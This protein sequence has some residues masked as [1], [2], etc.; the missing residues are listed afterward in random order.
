MIFLFPSDFALVSAFF[1]S[2]VSSI[3]SESIESSDFDFPRGA[4]SIGQLLINK[5]VT[6]QLNLKQCL[7]NSIFSLPFYLGF[8][9]VCYVVV[10]L[11]IRVD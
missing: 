7:M 6:D 9:F 1:A 4:R 2:D 3:I 5:I 10:V 8:L 11:V